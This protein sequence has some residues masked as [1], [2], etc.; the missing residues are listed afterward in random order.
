MPNVNKTLTD[1]QDMLKSGQALF[2]AAPLAGS[3]SAHFWQAQDKILNEVETYSS[4]WFKRRHD[5]TRTA[6]DVGQRLAQDAIGQPAVA[7]GILTEWQSQSMQ[8]LAEDAKECSEMMAHCAGA[9][10]GS[11]IET[12]EEVVKTARKS[13]KTAKSSPV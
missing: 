3:Q 4:A 10:L 8:R 1:L 9:I 13:T 11:E 2:A 5:A 6:M 7:M 12:V